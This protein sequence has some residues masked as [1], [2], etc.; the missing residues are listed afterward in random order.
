[1]RSYT[2]SDI[3]ILRSNRCLRISTWWDEIDENGKI[4]TNAIMAVLSF[5]FICVWDYH[6]S[7]LFKNH[8]IQF[9]K[10]LWKILCIFKS[11]IMLVLYT[12]EWEECFLPDKLFI[13]CVR[14]PYIVLKCRWIMIKT[15]LTCVL[16]GLTL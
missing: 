3:R 2:Q 6:F 16:Y 7:F 14:F 11:S 12:T 4:H 10:E 13:L 5:S 8:T 9:G 1:M 15:L